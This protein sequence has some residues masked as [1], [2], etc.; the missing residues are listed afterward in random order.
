MV[1]FSYLRQHLPSTVID[2]L[3]LHLFPAFGSELIEKWIAPA[4]PTDLVS[5]DTFERVVEQ[6]TQFV[7]S[8]RAEGWHGLECL[9][10]WIKQIPR[11]WINQRRA[12]SLDE[13]RTTIIN[14]D[15]KTSTVERVEKERVSRDDD[16]FVETG[17][18]EDWNAGWT[19]DNENDE[20]GAKAEGQ[21]NDEDASAWGLEDDV[22][23]A[24]TDNKDHSTVD[25]DVD[26]AWGWGDEDDGDVSTNFDQ[27]SMQ[28][29]K[30]QSVGSHSQREVMLKE[31][32]EIS[33]VPKTVL[34]IVARQVSDGEMLADTQ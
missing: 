15:G 30:P 34:S 14:C 21:N 3:R 12:Q 6:V 27:H 26:E 7:E 1:A 20:A 23:I 4:V 19:S 32:Y 5:M 16:M 9:G 33:D 13:V 18:A 24:E 2:R 8:L 25:D 31:F 10:S 17:T 22:D 29:P 28:E 11:F